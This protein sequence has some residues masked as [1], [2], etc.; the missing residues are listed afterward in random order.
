MNVRK[1]VLMLASYVVVAG[2]M[3]AATPEPAYAS[4][5][6]SN[7]LLCTNALAT[8]NPCTGGQ[9]AY[10]DNDTCEGSKWSIECSGGET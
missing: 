9:I 4:T 1:R 8:S 7:W 2:A 5:C 10:C 3:L 6:Y